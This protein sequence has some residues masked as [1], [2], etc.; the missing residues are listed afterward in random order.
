MTKSLLS[1][2][3]RA[4]EAA[5]AWLAFGLFRALPVDAASALGGCLASVVG[6]LLP[7]S[8]RARR[9]LE[10]AL[11]ERSAGEIDGIVRA[12]WANLGRVAAEYAHLGE[13]R[14][15][16][17]GGRI[18]VV[19]AEHLDAL[20]AGGT[21][22]ILFSAHLGNWEVAALGATQ[23]GVSLLQIYRAANNAAVDRLM[24][25]ARRPVGGV[26]RP[27][28]RR[29]AR[30]AAAALGRG[31]YLAMLVDQK[32][33]EGIP[34]PFFGRPAMTAP[35]LAALALRY[36]CPVLPA[37]VERLS[38]ATFRLTVYPP[39]DIPDSGDRQADSQALMASVNAVIEEWVRER[40]EQWLWLHRRWP[41]SG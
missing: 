41:E 26:F 38:G 12:M 34:V 32:L 14:C 27:K 2:L 3:R 37:R 10:L 40:P 19:G 23:R 28:G 11:P 31:E 18:E 7:V 30:E 6:P 29:G 1:S 5:V 24:A 21:G 35:A 20:R 13:F 17:P 25:L 9:N 15:Y 4:G 33:R 16:E 36:R 8:R 39:M 22:G